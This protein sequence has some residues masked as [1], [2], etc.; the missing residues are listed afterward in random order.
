M[1]LFA[2]N[3]V[4][5]LA[6]GITAAGTTVTVTTGQGA[7]FPAVTAPDYL[8]LTLD[9]GT[10][11]EVVRCTAHTAAA[12]TFTVTRAQETIGTT[13]AAA[14]A[15][16]DG[17][18][19]E[20]RLTAAALNAASERVYATQSTD[21][22]TASIATGRA[23]VYVGASASRDVLRLFSGTTADVASMQPH[24][25]TNG[26]G[27]WMP[28]ATATAPFVMG[29]FGFTQGAT[30]TIAAPGPSTTAPA[31]VNSLR[32][33]T[34]A[35]A[36]TT[37]N[38]T[39]GVFSNT[40]GP[41]WR[42]NAAGLGGFDVL[43]RFTIEAWATG[44]RLFV[45]LSSTASSAVAATAG[46]L[47]AATSGIGFGVDAGD[48]TWSLFTTAGGVTKTA[49]AGSP[50]L[51]AGQAYD[52]R[53]YAPPNAAWIGVRLQNVN[54]A[55]IYDGQ[56]SSNLPVSTTFLAVHANASNAALTTAGAIK[57]GVVRIYA[58]T[59]L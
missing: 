6:G 40:A 3:A 31:V 17:T 37:T 2:N 50:T 39:L 57:F 55:L 12:D 41:L 43:F 24:I 10:H 22:T 33:V 42:G 38:Q 19:V 28:G 44:G 30:G 53:L 51:A 14:Y 18:T 25:G 54:G 29:F 8:L 26:V 46:I 27:L 47:S 58:E 7:R 52:V 20:A 35:N 15:F 13:A 36:A 32:R 23:A 1:Q 56:V 11:V 4:A 9:D 5:T 45:G 21:P 16:S 34:W 59:D 48:T 49:V